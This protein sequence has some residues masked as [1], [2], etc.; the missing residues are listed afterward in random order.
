MSINRLWDEV[1]KIMERGRGYKLSKTLE[2]KKTGIEALFVKENKRN[3]VIITNKKVSVQQVRRLLSKMQEHNCKEGLIATLKEA[4]PQARKEAVENGIEIID[5]K[6]PLIYIF[7]HWLVPEHRVLSR[8]EEQEVINKYAGGDRRL[9]MKI[10][11][12]ITTKDP[13]V[14]ILKA[15]PG[16]IIE[17][18]R[19]VPP[20]EELKKKFGEKVGE[21]IYKILKRLIPA[22]E[23]IYYRVVVG[24]ED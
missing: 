14:R 13:A 6:Q 15:K 2:K 23:E 24:A 19:R 3:Y 9:A 10:F 4:T 12:K 1:R 21:E 18:R 16:R 22:G 7:D 20:L 17:I 11:P 8:E 5:S